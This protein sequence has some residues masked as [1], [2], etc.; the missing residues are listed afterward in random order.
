MAASTSPL[1]LPSAPGHNNDDITVDLLLADDDAPPPQDRGRPRTPPPSSVAGAAYDAHRYSLWN[2]PGTAAAAAATSSSRSSIN[3]RSAAS[4]SQ[5]SKTAAAGP[6]SP[7][8]GYC[9]NTSRGGG[10]PAGGERGGSVS[11]GLHG[12]SPGGPGG[13][14]PAVAAAAAAAAATASS[15]PPAA[16]VG[17]G[18]GG[19]ETLASP[20]SLHVGAVPPSS[21]MSP[22]HVFAGT[23]LSPLSR[24]NHGSRGG[25][26][27]GK[28]FSFLRIVEE[29]GDGACDGD[30]GGGDDVGVAA[31]IGGG[32]SGERGVAR[33][34]DVSAGHG[35]A[36]WVGY[37]GPEAQ[38][39]YVGICMQH[40]S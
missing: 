22:F 34:R 2:S 33:T 30:D 15:P 40:S 38:P 9:V 6:L 18:G 31:S 7:S 20:L 21:P 17:G 10:G 8:T 37:R 24:S 26:G 28:S 14:C 13:P 25:L 39:R 12:R 35:Q 3:T 27:G 16:R 5:A 23:Q 32:Q 11:W 36:W 19:A 29:Q 4:G 1:P